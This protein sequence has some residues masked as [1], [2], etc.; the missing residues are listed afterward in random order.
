MGKVGTLWAISGQ[1]QTYLL[2]IAFC[3]SCMHD[4]HVALTAAWQEA[5]EIYVC[6]AV[7]KLYGE[8]IVK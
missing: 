4:F 7:Q 5:T 8:I 2:V 6:M 3:I 1:F